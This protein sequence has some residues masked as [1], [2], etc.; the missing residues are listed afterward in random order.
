MIESGLTGRAEVKVGARRSETTELEILLREGRKREVRLMCRAV[1]HDV[2]NLRRTEFAGI[3]VAGMSPGSWRVL[4]A[5]ETAALWAQTE[6][7]DDRGN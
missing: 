4:Q 3:G 2:I 5:S 6:P 1:G 7:V